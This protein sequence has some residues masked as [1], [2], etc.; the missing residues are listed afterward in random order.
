MINRT[1]PFPIIAKLALIA[2]IGTVIYFGT[3]EPQPTGEVVQ[4][5]LDSVDIKAALHEFI[6]AQSE[7]GTEAKAQGKA[8]SD[9]SYE[10]LVRYYARHTQR[11]PSTVLDIIEAALSSQDLTI[12][13]QG[14]M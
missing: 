6:E 4:V 11:T 3:R 13:A 12:R 9:S 8:L 7:K 10:E 1:R 5:K 2:L 14:L